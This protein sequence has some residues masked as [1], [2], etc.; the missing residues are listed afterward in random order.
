[1]VIEI[2][3]FG[4]RTYFL[5]EGSITRVGSDCWCS[6]VFPNLAGGSAVRVEVVFDRRRAYICRIIADF[7]FF[8]EDGRINFYPQDLRLAGLLERG[9]S[10]PGW[11]EKARGQVVFFRYRPKRVIMTDLQK[12]LLRE[13]I[14]RDFGEGTWERLPG[15]V[16]RGLWADNCGAV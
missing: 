6:R 12:R 16:R 10:E 13:R 15:Q 4:T 1:M 11:R 14:N 7:I 2:N 3:A 5:K 9:F 8:D